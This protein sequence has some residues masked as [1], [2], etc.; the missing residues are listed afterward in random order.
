MILVISPKGYYATDRL[1]EEAKKAGVEFEAV[2]A[3]DLAKQ[4]FKVD[5]KKYQLLF[6][7]QG[8]PYAKQIFDLAKKFIKAG[9]K[10]IDAPQ[11]LEDVIAGK[12]YSHQKLGT[13]GLAVPNTVLLEEAGDIEYPVVVKW[14]YGLKGEQVFLIKNKQELELLSLKYPKDQLIVQQFIKADYEYKVITVGFRS[15][16]SILKFKIDPSGFRINFENFE[17]IRKEDTLKICE[18]A[19]NASKA[20]NREL[21]KVDILQKHEKLYILEVN[22]WPGLAS[23][24]S[25]TK[26]N[27]SSEFIRYLSRTKKLETQSVA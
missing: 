1:S 16:P 21:A 7:R 26:Y 13:A 19:E 23:F 2:D 3:G 6:F 17:V 25:L 9:K 18:L 5:V 14:I 11:I 20:L 15:V 24:E 10:V 22:R 8:Y 12:W 27:V 4:N